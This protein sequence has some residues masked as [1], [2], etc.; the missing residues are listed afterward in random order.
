MYV[1]V[2]VRACVCV[3]VRACVCVYICVCMCV[4]T[5][6]CVYIYGKKC[7][8]WNFWKIYG[9][10]ELD[11]ETHIYLESVLPVEY[12]NESLLSG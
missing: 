9:Q 10:N 7:Q 2:H 11:P 6:V 1:R 12:L 3:H 8:K 4:C 5:Y